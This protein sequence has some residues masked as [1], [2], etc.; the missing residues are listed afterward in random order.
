M[1]ES[2]R[3]A[4]FAAAAGAIGLVTWLAWEVTAVQEFSE[5]EKVAMEGKLLFPGFRDPLAATSL[6]IVRYDEEAALEDSFKVAQIDGEWSIPSHLNYPADAEDQLAEAASSMMELRV[7]DKASDDP[8]THGMYGVVDPSSK[9][10][11]AAAEDVGVR[12]VMQDKDDKELMA[13]IIGKEVPDR[14]ELRYVRAVDKNAVDKNA[15]YTMV[16]KT[17]KLSNKFEDWIEEDLLK[18]SSWDIRRVEIQDYTFDVV[19]DRPALE[20]KGQMTL[21]HDDTGDPKWKLAEDLVLDTEK[22]RVPAEMAEDEELDADKLDDLSSA[23]DDLKIVDVQRKPAGLSADL[24]VA[25]TMTADLETRLSLQLRGFYLV[26][27]QERYLQLLSNQGE[28]RVVMKD[29]VE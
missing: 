21:E 15:V 10:A 29:G 16:V 3:T 25:G 17:D 9:P 22:G 24:R 1:N 12:V 27:V 26:P 2:I 23:L 8:K 19:D 13:L 7:V 20:W 5:P 18:L 28:T 11:S 14:D 4:I 6:E